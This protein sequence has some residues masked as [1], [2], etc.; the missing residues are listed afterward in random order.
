MLLLNSKGDR[1][2][3]W[4]SIDLDLRVRQNC[5]IVEFFKTLNHY[6]VQTPTQILFLT[7]SLT[8]EASLCSRYK[9]R[10]AFR[11][12]RVCRSGSYPLQICVFGSREGIY[13]YFAIYLKK[14]DLLELST[15][16]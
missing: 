6:W 5:T 14:V 4:L 15:L 16:R 1:Q 8:W 11:K 7:C 13:A 12:R 9:R 2:V 10:V 3:D